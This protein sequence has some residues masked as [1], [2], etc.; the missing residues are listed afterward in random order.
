LRGFPEDPLK[1]L[2]RARSG[3]RLFLRGRIFVGDP[4]QH[5][6]YA[7]HALGHMLDGVQD[8]PR[9][10]GQD[11]VAVLPHTL[12][13]QGQVRLITQFIPG[14]A[15]DLHDA[16]Q[17]RLADTPNEARSQAVSEQHAEN[18][19]LLGIGLGFPRQV[20]PGVTP[21]GGQDQPV[22]FSSASHKK[23]HLVFFGLQH[24]VDRS[25]REPFG[26]FA[27]QAMQYNRFQRHGST[28]HTHPL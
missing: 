2:R 11:E 18:R 13:A 21:G 14:G 6:A 17:T 1:I 8:L 26:Q 5:L 25:A 22:V 10:V 23:P 3:V 24:A 19:R 12:Q 28:S 15:V 27:H 20:N 16:L 9:P 4:G 7:A